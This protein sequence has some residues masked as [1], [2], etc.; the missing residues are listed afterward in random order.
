MA[1]LG[2]ESGLLEAVDGVQFKEFQAA[3]DKNG[4]GYGWKA[5]KVVTEDGYILHMFRLTTDGNGEPIESTKGPVYLQH[6]LRGNAADWFN[7][8]NPEDVDASTDCTLALE[9]SKKGYDVWLGNTRGGN[10]SLGHTKLDRKDYWDFDWAEL[11]M[12]DIPSMVDHVYQST[13]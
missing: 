10:F 5:H 2:N 8:K 13:G 4:E 7:C 12:Y 6:G 3:I 9:L 1:A 11:G